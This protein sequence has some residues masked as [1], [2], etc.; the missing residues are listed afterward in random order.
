MKDI[1]LVLIA[2]LMFFS[3]CMSG[4]TDTGTTSPA[5]EQATSPAAPSTAAPTTEA[6][7]ATQ[8]SA[9]AL[10]SIVPT[11]QAP[12]TTHPGVT[13]TQAPATTQAPSAPAAAKVLIQGFSFKPSSITVGVGSTVTW[14]NQDSAPHTVA[15]DSGGELASGTLSNGGTYAH[16]FNAPGTYPYHC[17]IHRSMKGTV[18]VQ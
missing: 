14:E 4:T 9:T 7:S 1:V 13:T 6:P 2:G 11:T 10:P 17:G 18:T 8:A 12:T 15:S 3:G 16:T 5:M